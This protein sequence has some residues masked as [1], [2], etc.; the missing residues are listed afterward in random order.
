MNTKLIGIVAVVVVLAGAG[1][2]FFLRSGSPLKTGGNYSSSN[3]FTGTLKAA[4]DL[5]IPMKC[6][7][8]VEG[9]EYESV[10][11]GKKFRGSLNTETGVGNVIMKDNCMYSWQ[12][13]SNQGV[14][15]CFDE[16]ETNIWEQTGD[17]GE[18]AGEASVPDTLKCYPTTIS[19]NEFDLPTSV[20]FTDFNIPSIPTSTPGSY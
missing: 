17:T 5:G 3:P 1:W 20:N 14:K 9:V 4:V 16:N 7:Y 19:P 12:E 13:N 18:V 2:Y 6:T 11:Q 8:E 15:I 10:I